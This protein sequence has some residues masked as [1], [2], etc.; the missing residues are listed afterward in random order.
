MRDR[1][2]TQKQQWTDHELHSKFVG[3]TYLG[4]SWDS[5]EQQQ[6]AE[7]YMLSYR[8]LP[9]NLEKGHREV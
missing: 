2:K 6:A 4:D 5:P 9:R 1:K 3:V 7:E 8:E